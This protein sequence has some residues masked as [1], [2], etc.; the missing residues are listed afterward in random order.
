MYVN[1][2]A[3]KGLIEKFESDLKLIKR[4]MPFEFYVNR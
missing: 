4:I 3:L 1:S 2:A